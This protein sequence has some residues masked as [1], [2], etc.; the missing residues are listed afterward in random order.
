MENDHGETETDHGE[1]RTYIGNSIF[2]GESEKHRFLTRSLR[3]I[4]SE[5]C[6]R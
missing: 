4:N 1:A 5:H 3:L 2:T 6:G